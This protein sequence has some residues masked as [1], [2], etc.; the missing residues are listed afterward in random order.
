MSKQRHRSPWI[1]LAAALA[2]VAIVAA[3]V[4]WVVKPK[5]LP[6]I[7][8]ASGGSY[9]V[10]LTDRPSSLDIRT[11]DER[12]VERVLVGNVYETL[13]THDYTENNSAIKANLVARFSQ[14]DD[15]LHYSFYLR[16]GLTFAD[17]EPLTAGSVVASLQAIITDDYVGKDTLG[18]VA[19]VANDNDTTFTIDLHKPNPSLLEALTGR[20]GIVYR[21]TDADA[22]WTTQSHGSGPFTM[23]GADGD[24]ITLERN[25]H[26]W[27]DAPAA[28]RIDLKYYTDQKAMAAD[29]TD[30]ALDMALP[31]DA[32]VAQQ[33]DADSV[34]S[35]AHGMG[36]AKTL[37]A[38]NNAATSPFS[39]EQVRK[40]ARTAI[41]AEGIAK[42]TPA[43]EAQLSGPI[44]QLQPGYVDLDDLFPYDPEQALAMR[45]YFPAGYFEP[46]TLLTDAAHA[47]LGT[48][49]MAQL[50]AV[51]LPVS[52]E[53]VDAAELN[54]RVERGD[55]TCALI[56]MDN[57]DD[58]VKFV[59]GST[60]F[61]YQNGQA[62]DAWREAQAATDYATWRERLRDFDRVVSEDAASAWLYTG[63]AWVAARQGVW[64]VSPQLSDQRL[65]LAR[66]SR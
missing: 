31:T 27:G 11:N 51:G 49:V 20:A 64:G 4:V 46:F 47:A 22:D 2:T 15:G 33:L 44:S 17:G 43:A 19:K 52:L 1:L 59:D 7:G 63:K 18:D 65:G 57:P 40:L 35:V 54:E 21:T 13:L 25:D 29:L 28:A 26:Y 48:T 23:A 6:G 9:T 34:L 10:G 5:G 38:F 62:Q 32:D 58:Y 36:T 42:S 3:V 61:N 50:T 39:D 8:N 55:Y 60:M 37:V 53:Q 41:D 30:G 14:S 45:S 56:D 24:T 16:D 12:A 66:M